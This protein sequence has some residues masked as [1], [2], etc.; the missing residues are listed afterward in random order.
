MLVFGSDV[1]VS[2][3]S[4][5]MGSP[6]SRPAGGISLPPQTAASCILAVVCLTAARLTTVA[7]VTAKVLEQRWPNVAPHD[8]SAPP[9]SSPSCPTHTGT[10]A[11]PTW[12]PC[13]AGCTT[14]P[15]LWRNAAPSQ[16]PR[17]RLDPTSRSCSIRK[18]LWLPWKPSPWNQPVQQGLVTRTGPALQ[19]QHSGSTTAPELATI[20]RSLKVQRTAWPRPLCPPAHPSLT[21]PPA[22]PCPPLWRT[23]T[24]KRRRRRRRCVAQPPDLRT[25]SQ[26]SSPPTLLRRTPPVVRRSR[27][28]MSS[29]CSHPRSQD[30][31]Q[32]RRWVSRYDY[33]WNFLCSADGGAFLSVN[34]PE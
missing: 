5:F 19:M 27:E 24:R 18:P 25:T 9:S 11:T 26:M 20:S 34:N 14:P 32:R 10:R 4:Q 21:P 7:L 3:P 8:R 30:R 31:S 33:G 2:V 23:R 12:R 16:N 29:T 13:A 17:A 22:A 6:S 15:G 1:S 28:M